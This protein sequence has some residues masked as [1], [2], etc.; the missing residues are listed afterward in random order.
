MALTDFYVDDTLR[1]SGRND[2]EKWSAS[3]VYELATE[4]KEL[5]VKQNKL[6]PIV[7]D[8]WGRP[9]GAEL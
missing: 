1:I 5:R 8:E 3:V 7:I 2:L 9:V 4:I 6:T